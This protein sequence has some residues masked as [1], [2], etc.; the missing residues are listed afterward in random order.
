MAITDKITP[1]NIDQKLDARIVPELPE[2]PTSK[3]A[4]LLLIK[5][6]SDRAIGRIIGIS[7]QTISK[8]MN[9]KR[10]KLAE[11]R[12]TLDKLDKL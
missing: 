12:E 5:Q 3:L 8:Y 1:D 4:E 9:A 2:V 6:V 10:T 11:R 7:S